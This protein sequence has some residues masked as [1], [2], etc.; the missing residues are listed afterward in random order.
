MSET[1]IPFYPIPTQA[2]TTAHWVEGG[3]PGN[4]DDRDNSDRHLLI[5]D[6]DN[7][8]LYELYNVFYDGTKV[9]RLLRRLLQHE[10]EFPAARGLDLRGCGGAGDLPGLVRYG[11]A[12]AAG[13]PASTPIRHAFHVTVNSTNGYV[14]PAS[15]LTCDVNDGDSCPTFALPMGARLRLKPG[16]V[17]ASANPG[18]QR[19]VQAL[20]TC[21]AHRGRQRVQHVHQRHVRRALGQRHPEPRAGQ[22][23]RGRLRSHPARFRPSALPTPGNL[24]Q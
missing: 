17:V 22:H 11:E 19:I 4:V 20:K 14:F 7:K 10:P 9:E 16:K 5:I 2:I 15:H 6:Q 24:D 13:M 23:H 1:S 12:Y 18:V 21:E 8:F 3:A